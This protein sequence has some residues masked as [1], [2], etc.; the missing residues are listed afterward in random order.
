MEGNL[1]LWMLPATVLAGMAGC[2]IMMKLTNAGR[3]TEHI[4]FRR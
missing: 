3:Q 1:P 2:W 4:S